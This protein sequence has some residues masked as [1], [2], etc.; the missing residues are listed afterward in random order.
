M[1]DEEKRWYRLTPQTFPNLLQAFAIMA[2]VI[3]EKNLE[4]CSALF[5]YLAQSGGIQSL[6]GNCMVE[7]RRTVLSAEGNQPV[8]A[9]GTQVC[10]CDL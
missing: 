6:Q 4:N 5:C 9:V 2:S 10:G 1:E 7:V 3:G 8:L